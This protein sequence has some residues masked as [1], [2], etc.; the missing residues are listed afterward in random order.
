MKHWIKGAALGL[1]LAAAIAAP[2]LAQRA[3]VT[4]YTSLEN[5]QLGPFKQAIEAAVPE[6]EVVW[7]RD[8][9]G[10]IGRASCRERVFITV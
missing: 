7:V 4:I 5:D 9:T 2:A 8:S 3:K 1:A 6:A 10:E